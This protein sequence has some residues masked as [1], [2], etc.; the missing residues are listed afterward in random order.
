[1]YGLVNKAIEGLVVQHHGP[2]VWRR[3][4]DVAGLDAEPFVGLQSYSDEITYALV[5]AASQLLDR[6][7]G[8]LLRDFGRYWVEFVARSSYGEW[9]E[10]ADTFEDCLSSLDEMH[11]RLSLSLPELRPPSFELQGGEGDTIRLLYFSEREGLAPMVVGLIEGL[12]ERFGKTA[13]VQ[14][15]PGSKGPGGKGHEEFDIRLASAGG[16]LSDVA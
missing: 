14:H 3:I 13:T 10:A 1:M 8:D 5:G 6:S 4:L 11:A 16:S 2:D 7:A 15:L 12:A 9:L